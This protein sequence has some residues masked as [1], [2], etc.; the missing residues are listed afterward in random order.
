MN[1]ETL[2]PTLFANFG[3]VYARTGVKSCS[4]DHGGGHSSEQA[5]ETLLPG[6]ADK[7]IEDILV[8]ATLVHG[9]VSVRL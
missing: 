5:H 6:D 1:S 8:V 9:Q 4:A 7:G 2:Q 3:K